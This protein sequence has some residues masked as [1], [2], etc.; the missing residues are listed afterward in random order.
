MKY[1]KQKAA[2]IILAFF[3]AGICYC[4]SRGH[5]NMTTVVTEQTCL[6]DRAAGEESAVADMSGTFFPEA[7]SER[8]SSTTEQNTPSG[9]LEEAG[10]K[11][12]LSC[13]VHI[14][15]EVISPGVYELEEGSRVFQV[16]EMAGGLTEKAAA[17]SLNM[18]E[19]IS[20]GMKIVVLDEEQAKL[21]SASGAGSL[22][23]EK[24]A[25][26]TKVNLN[27]ASK[28]ELMTLKGIGESRAEDIIAFRE[29]RGKFQRIEDIMKVS[30]I[31][32]AA[33]QKIRDNITV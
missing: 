8:G 24:E 27:T 5:E 30:G 25:G 6:S 11:Q 10:Q 9:G 31:K 20:D 12:V 17:E 22:S 26:S 3:T 4:L 2:L 16:V 23:G 28:E 18:A 13:Y 21:V 32:D 19:R 29:S 14:C 1:Q 33:F 7:D 15:G